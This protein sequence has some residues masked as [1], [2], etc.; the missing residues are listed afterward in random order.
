MRQR[1]KGQNPKQLSFAKFQLFQCLWEQYNM[2]AVKLHVLQANDKTH[3]H[4]CRQYDRCVIP[5]LAVKICV[6]LIS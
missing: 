2:L 5:I 1:C 4:L 6:F 3:M